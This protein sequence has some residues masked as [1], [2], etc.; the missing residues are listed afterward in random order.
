[1][2]DAKGQQFEDASDRL[3]TALTAKTVSPR[4]AGNPEAVK[5]IKERYL[6]L[7]SDAEET[8]QAKLQAVYRQLN[9]QTEGAAGQQIAAPARPA[10]SPAPTPRSAPKGSTTRL[11]MPDGSIATFDASGKRL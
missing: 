9:A 11:K 5:A 4:A 2:K 10:T 1:M 3:A 6:P 7:P 8:R